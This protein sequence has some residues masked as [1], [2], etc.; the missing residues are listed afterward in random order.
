MIIWAAIPKD[1]F[2][3]NRNTYSAAVEAMNANATGKSRSIYLK[4]SGIYSRER[5]G[6][7]A[8]TSAIR[9]ERSSRPWPASQPGV[10]INHY[11]RIVC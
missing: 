6:M 11:V 10:Q 5:M 8:A 4:P 2:W 3:M 1:S 7:H 9:H